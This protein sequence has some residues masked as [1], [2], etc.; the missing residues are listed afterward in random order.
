MERKH[1]Q[2]Q[3]GSSA[4]TRGLHRVLIRNTFKV[5]ILLILAGTSFVSAC[6][7]DLGEYSDDASGETSE[8]VQREQPLT[9]TGVS[10]ELIRRAG[11]FG[12]VMIPYFITGPNSRSIGT[13]TIIGP[14]AVLTAGHHSGAAL[15]D[16]D[17]DAGIV[18][19]PMSVGT[20]TGSLAPNT[21]YGHLGES[22]GEPN[23]HP[24]WW[25]EEGNSDSWPSMHDQLVLF[26]PDLTPQVLAE[27]TRDF[28]ITPAAVDPYMV[29]A[30]RSVV[31]CGSGPGDRE[32]ATATWKNCD[33]SW[34]GHLCLN[35]PLPD[36]GD[37]GGPTL[38][39]NDYTFEGH[40]ISG[41]RVVLAT[42]QNSGGR[43]NPLNYSPGKVLSANQ[44]A[45]VRLNQLWVN[46][47]LNDADYDDIP[48]PC[49]LNPATEAS[50]VA[51]F[52]ANNLCP[53]PTA[54][55]LWGPRDS[56]YWTGNPAVW[57]SVRRYPTAA[58][59]C[60]PGYAI[61]GI[62]GRAGWLIDE[63]AV[64][65]TPLS[66]LD[67]PA[68]GCYDK[69]WTDGFGEGSGGTAFTKTCNSGWV[70]TKMWVQDGLN[71]TN[72]INVMCQPF[73]QTRAGTYSSGVSL[74][75][76]GNAFGTLDYGAPGQW[77]EC[78]SGKTL[79]GLV[80]RSSDTYDEVGDDVADTVEGIFAVCDDVLA[81]HTEYVGGTGGTPYGLACPSNWVAV[82]TTSLA[83]PNQGNQVGM[84]GLLCADRS[85]PNWN[86]ENLVVVHGSYQK[87]S[88][89]I[90]PAK[91][92]D[93]ES[94]NSEIATSV[95]KCANGHA[96]KRIIS[97]VS[98][99]N[100]RINQI[101]SLLCESLVSSST[102]TISV[103]E[104]ISSGSVAY[105][106]CPSG[107]VVDGLFVQSGWLTDGFAPHCSP[108]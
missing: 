50:T 64:Q 6:V 4:T 49:D 67:K 57:V 5:T 15:I 60:K 96:I 79:T 65:C 40:G 17:H 68:L 76:I 34:D 19:K 38:G 43:T 70:A 59:Q 14:Y 92:E 99:S 24:G 35:N 78:G 98:T 52:T 58:L 73:E 33:D 83:D 21:P 30:S 3:S 75:P 42:T 93:F 71:T 45:T 26:V 36:G 86:N 32:Y 53:A 82:G 9:G 101:Y 81:E 25:E 48:T 95:D 74:G 10:S 56:T 102:S 84:F 88:N 105:S 51:A 66:C 62:K 39:Y 94:Y 46:A 47:R 72:E 108:K 80:V 22:W 63:L 41:P 85:A 16:W 27:M 90:Y 11:E 18:P 7:E 103:L 44:Q 69:Y 61:T 97:R 91:V 107:E 106:T 31:G 23:F 1:H 54:P 2:S 29:T 104:G 100:N 87:D 12:E 8:L 28:D 20:P 77:A 37:S 13:G 89:N 55:N